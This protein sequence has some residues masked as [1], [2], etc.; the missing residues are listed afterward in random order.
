MAI[1][2]GSEM[3]KKIDELVEYVRRSRN[4]LEVLKVLGRSISTTNKVAARASLQVGT[5]R[6]T[7]YGLVRKG[8]VKKAAPKARRPM[9]Y[10]T[11]SLGD[12]VLRMRDARGNIRWKGS[13]KQRRI[14]RRVA[15]R[16]L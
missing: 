16:R 3:S 1:F 11:T 14:A 2:G 7:I 6:S 8:L 10:E 9:I 5:V 15:S 12:A 13:S 4:R